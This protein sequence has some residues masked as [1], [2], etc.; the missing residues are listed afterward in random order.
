MTRSS[1]LTIVAPAVFVLLWSTGWIAAKYAAPHADP[2][3]FLTIRFSAAAVVIAVF[4]LA[5]RAPWPSGRRAWM[6]AI[7]SGVLLHGIYLGGVWWAVKHGLSAG[8]SGLLAALQPLLT[9]FLGPWILRETV[10]PRQWLGVAVGL[11]GVILVLSPKL[12]PAFGLVSGSS[13]GGVGD[14]AWLALGV[15]V[16]GMLAVTAGS[17]YQKR[18]VAGADLRT[19]TSVQYLGGVLVVAPVALAT[20]SLRFDHSLEVYAVLAWSVLVLS[21]VTVSLMLAMINRG[22]V[23]RVSALIFLVPSTV[24]VLAW[25]LFGETLNGV[26]GCGMLLTAAG[27]YLA[28]A[29]S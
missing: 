22:E 14:T 10:S 4:A 1:V 23:M 3:W 9:A 19:V 7:V 6:H 26:Q 18:Y 8:L 15:N 29:R 24:A 2:L 11:A 27:V 17:F 12:F 28:T 5:V 25:L 13:P 16:I 20:E 21:V